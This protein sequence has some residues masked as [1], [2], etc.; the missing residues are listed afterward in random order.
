MT[1][2]LARRSG[3]AAALAALLVAAVGG[4]AVARGGEKAV[5]LVGAGAALLILLVAPLVVVPR[6]A[7]TYL[8][9]EA[10]VILLLLSTLVFR[11]RDTTALAQNPLDAAAAY[12][13]LCVTAALVLA[14]IAL[15]QPARAQRGRMPFE[16]K[17]Y[18]VYVG[19]VF[20]G[21][22]VSVAPQLTAY[23]G[24]ELLTGIA[25]VAG[26]WHT[27][28]PEAIQRIERL[29]YR[30]VVTLVALVWIGV[31]LFPGRAIIPS[32]PIPFSIQGIYPNIA[33]NGVGDLG[34]ILLLWTLGRLVSR[35]NDIRRGT[36]LFLIGVGAVTLV[37]A[38]YRTGYVGLVVALLVLALAR[39]RLA[40]GI[41]GIVAFL[42]V[43]WFSFHAVVHDI[44]PYAL[45]GESPTKAK[46]LSG[47]LTYWS[48]AIPVW[49]ESPAI[50]RGLGTAS[51]FQVLAPLGQGSTSTVHGTW[52]EVLV[53]TGV[54]GVV[55]LAVFLLRLWWLALRDLLSRWG[56][57]WP[58]LV[59]TF[60]IVHS[61]TGSTFELFGYY[62]LLLLAL[63]FS[64][65][66]GSRAAPSTAPAAAGAG[67]AG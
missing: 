34:A 55:L 22:V 19:V 40:L 12:R 10:P 17:L 2:V 66:T 39:G 5:L 57:V 25:A 59:V 18:A 45:R 28:G 8:A 26:A 1:A 62:T 4:A 60:V 30:F 11:V 23:R 47:R 54:V 43:G 35:R 29:L 27:A 63:A 41:V 42:V 65:T 6:I 50:G 37:A 38:Q 52:I 53:G 32:H 14:W 67:P 3:I 48:A 15:L 51:R 61:L 24:F 64:L 56:R 7:R 44:Q 36:A 49:R 20:L 58:S 16:F 21:A 33:S 46:Q 13:V 9:I 31:A